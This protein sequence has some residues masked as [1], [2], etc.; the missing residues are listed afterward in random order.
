M[1]V[2]V[3]IQTI[4][5]GN[6][7]EISFVIDSEF[8]GCCMPFNTLGGAFFFLL[9]FSVGILLCPL[10]NS[11]AHQS[12]NSLVLSFYCPLASAVWFWT[13]HLF[14]NN[15]HSP[16]LREWGSQEALGNG[17]CSLLLRTL[18][19]F[20]WVN[21]RQECQWQGCG[22]ADRVVLGFCQASN[23]PCR[24]PTKLPVMWELKWKWFLLLHILLLNFLRT[25]WE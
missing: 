3:I 17:G 21:D 9:P 24:C 13:H 18:T 25:V 15:F 4:V 16:P 19:S 8:F 6:V 11:L 12:L 1:A 23:Q 20:L 22:C 14:W 7:L 5:Q 2:C 10:T